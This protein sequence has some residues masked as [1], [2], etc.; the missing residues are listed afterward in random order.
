MPREKQIGV[1]TDCGETKPLFDVKNKVCGSCA[2][3]KG[4]GR[5][6]A[7]KQKQ[8]DPSA[9][10]PGETPLPADTGR[11]KSTS[12]PPA[13]EEN[14]PASASNGTE[15]YLCDACG[16]EVRYGQRQCSCGVWCDWRNTP[17]Q[18]DP[19]LVIC[20]ECGAICGHVENATKCPHCNYG[21]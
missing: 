14:S 20:P 16:K 1:C 18:D 13:T 2:G 11:Q 6:T 17:V 5:P 8:K 9:N 19:D 15:K 4:G 7:L 3:K 10:V 21:G 12:N